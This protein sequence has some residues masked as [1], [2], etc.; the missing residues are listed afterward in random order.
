MSYMNIDESGIQDSIEGFLRQYFD[1][2]QKYAIKE[3]NALS[4]FDNITLPEIDYIKIFRFLRSAIDQLRS[5]DPSLPNDQFIKFSQ[6]LDHN[7]KLYKEFLSKNKEAK[8]VFDIEYLHKYNKHFMNLSEHI[9]NLKS[10]IA[11][12]DRMLKV[13]NGKLIDMKKMKQ[14]K[15]PKFKAINK[16]M[17]NTLSVYDKDKKVLDGL[18]RKESE[19]RKVAEGVFLKIFPK[20]FSKI[21]ISLRALL[22]LKIHLLNKI[23]WSLSKKSDPIC[24]FFKSLV[25]GNMNL[26]TYIS[27]YLSSNQSRGISIQ[28]RNYLETCRDKLQVFK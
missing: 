6:N 10:S 22:S 15:T 9:D 11:S 21:N 13:L 24:G 23:L 25:K 20:Y 7:M 16:Q 14:D 4:K 27:Y 18:V 8:S 26:A 28:E 1:D 17:A 12:N 19:Y 2:L 5:I 3:K